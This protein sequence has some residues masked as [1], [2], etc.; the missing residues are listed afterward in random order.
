M[1]KTGQIFLLATIFPLMLGGNEL[2]SKW[3][4]I[5]TAYDDIMRAYPEV[6]WGI[7]FLLLSLIVSIGLFLQERQKRRRDRAN[8]L[9]SLTNRQCANVRADIENRMAKENQ[10]KADDLKRRTAEL[11]ERENAFKQ[12]SSRL[13][14]REQ[15]VI[16][17]QAE[18]EKEHI[19]VS[20]KTDLRNPF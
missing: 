10:V 7:E 3:A 8:E 15:Q 1:R 2:L 13:H 20:I 19:G 12:T 4:T 18:L 9:K 6:I 16:G 11:A 14:C 5:E 17:K